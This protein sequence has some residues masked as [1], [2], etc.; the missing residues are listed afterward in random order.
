MGRLKKAKVNKVLER[1]KK[2][3]V[4][5][6]QMGESLIRDRVDIILNICCSVQEV[7]TADLIARYE[8][9]PGEFTPNAEKELCRILRIPFSYAS[10]VSVGL[11]DQMVTEATGGIIAKIPKL[12]IYVRGGYICLVSPYPA[13]EMADILKAFSAEGNILAISGDPLEGEYSLR[14]KLGA[15][16]TSDPTS[17]IYPMMALRVSPLGLRGVGGQFGLFRQVSKAGLLRSEKL[18]GMGKIKAGEIKAD[19]IR[20]FCSL[21]TGEAQRFQQAYADQSKILM[22]TQIGEPSAFISTLQQKKALPPSVLKRVSSILTYWSEVR[23]PELP[24]HITSLY[25]FL[26]LVAFVARGFPYRQMVTIEQKAHALALS[27][28]AAA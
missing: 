25:E 16:L 20:S 4:P 12:Y 10:R 5:L 21:M 6:E 3:V 15:D 7:S 26:Q 17:P 19:R 2:A 13:V 1:A 18:S 9:G 28:T 27:S 11:K 24:E 23:V 22:N 8:A 14:V